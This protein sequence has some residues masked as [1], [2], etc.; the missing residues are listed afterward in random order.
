MVACVCYYLAARLSEW[1]WIACLISIAGTTF[2]TSHC[3]SPIKIRQIVNSTGWVTDTFKTDESAMKKTFTPALWTVLTYTVP[4]L[5]SGVCVCMYVCMCV[6]VCIYIFKHIFS[7]HKQCVL[8]LLGEYLGLPF[9]AV[10]YIMRCS[11]ILIRNC[12]TTF[13]SVCGVAC[14][15][16]QYERLN[17]TTFLLTLGSSL[18]N[19]SQFNGYHHSAIPLWFE[20][21]L[22]W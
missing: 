13:P 2:Q 1:C 8:F 5:P 16:Q 7:C 12:Q 3:H 4:L 17:Q 10:I 6:C 20:F 15:H 11:L 14:S 9:I 18:F 21:A 22:L 19:F